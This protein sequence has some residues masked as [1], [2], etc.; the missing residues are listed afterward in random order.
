MASCYNCCVRSRVYSTFCTCY[1][2]MHQ[3][4]FGGWAL[5]GTG[6]RG[7]MLS[8]RCKI[9]HT[10]LGDWSCL[11]NITDDYSESM[12]VFQDVLCSYWSILESLDISSSS[13][14]KAASSTRLAARFTKFPLMRK[15]PLHQ[16]SVLVNFCGSCWWRVYGILNASSDVSEKRFILLLVSA[17]YIVW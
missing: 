4:A 11:Y 16:V 5:P 6:F 7:W 3:N 14:S 9:L 15:K 1:L 10:L 2:R 8:L 17:F 13:R 12:R